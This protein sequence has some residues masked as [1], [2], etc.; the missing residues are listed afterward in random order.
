MERIEKITF[1]V[2]EEEDGDGYFAFWDDPVGGG[3][4]TT[5]ETLTELE[6]NIADAVQC[7]FGADQAPQKVKIQFASAKTLQ[8]A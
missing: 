2:A 7:H 4:T 5:G 8:L 1:T 3:I 6:A